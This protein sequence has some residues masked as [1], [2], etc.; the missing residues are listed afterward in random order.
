MECEKQGLGEHIPRLVVGNKCDE[1]DHIT[2]TTGTAQRFADH[3][4]MPVGRGNLIIQHWLVGS[5]KWQI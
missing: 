5:Q 2:V 1:T 3:H 4:N